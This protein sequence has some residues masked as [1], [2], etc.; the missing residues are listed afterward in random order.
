[1]TSFGRSLPSDGDRDC[2]RSNGERHGQ[3]VKGDCDPKGER[4][5]AWRS[6]EGADPQLLAEYRH[7]SSTL[8]QQVHAVLPGDRVLV[9]VARDV[10]EQG[11]LS[12]LVGD[13]TE[14]VS[15]G[16]IVHLRPDTGNR[17]G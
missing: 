6:A 4:I 17:R 8:G 14:T 10:D 16:D 3:G 12:I 5:R 11:R 15:A 9:G 13:R 7:R 2:S 1:M